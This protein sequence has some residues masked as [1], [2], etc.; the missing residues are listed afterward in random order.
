MESLERKDGRGHSTVFFLF[1]AVQQL[2]RTMSMELYNGG[3]KIS[4]T[5]QKLLPRKI[6]RKYNFTSAKK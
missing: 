2:P 4:T 1:Q 6:L 3:S 5:V